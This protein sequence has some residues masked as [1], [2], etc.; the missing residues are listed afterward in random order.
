MPS[1]VDCHGR[2][3]DGARVSVEDDTPQTATVTSRGR[4]K[5]AWEV[6]PLQV[7]RRSTCDP[8]AALVDGVVAI[9]AFVDPI[10]NVASPIVSC[11]DVMAAIGVIG[12][13]ALRSIRTPRHDLRVLRLLLLKNFD[14]ALMKVQGLSPREKNMRVMRQFGLTIGVARRRLQRVRAPRQWLHPDS[15]VPSLVG[16]CAQSSR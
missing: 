5:G 12:C 3:R 11:V 2:A 15:T 4:F 9:V 14:S 8:N 16:V 1:N 7:H 13:C 10:A 6:V